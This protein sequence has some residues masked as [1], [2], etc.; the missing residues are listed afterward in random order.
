MSEALGADSALQ[1]VLEK[2]DHDMLSQHSSDESDPQ[3]THWSWGCETGMTG[4]EKM[5]RSEGREYSDVCFDL[6]LRL[7]KYSAF[8]LGLCINTDFMFV[9]SGIVFKWGV[10]R[11]AKALQNVMKPV[12]LSY[13]EEVHNHCVR[14]RKRFTFVSK[15]SANPHTG[16]LDPSVCRVSVRKVRLSKWPRQLWG[17]TLGS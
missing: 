4:L 2:L 11:N 10:W 3:W 13:R 15:M 12:F 17:Q 8:N 7:G 5:W 1:L 16:V 6:K 9:Q 14:W